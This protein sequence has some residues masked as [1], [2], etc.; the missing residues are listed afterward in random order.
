MQWN[1]MKM[2][3]KWE[4]DGIKVPL[5]DLMAEQWQDKE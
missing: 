3:M 5:A 1:E 2:K 4:K